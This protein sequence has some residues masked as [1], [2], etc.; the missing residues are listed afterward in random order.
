MSSVQRMARLMAAWSVVAL[1]ACG[2]GGGDPAPNDD[3]TPSSAQATS[4]TI[5]IESGSSST[6][7][8]TFTLDG[9]SKASYALGTIKVTEVEY[10]SDVFDV[11]KVTAS[12]DATKYILL[13]GDNHTNDVFGCASAGW[14]D[15]ELVQI[16]ALTPFNIGRCPS[17]FNIDANT[18]RLTASHVSLTGAFDASKRLKISVDIALTSAYSAE[19]VVESGSAPTKP[20]T[21]ILTGSG[22]ASLSAE[23]I[24]L[25]LTYR[26]S[27]GVTVLL[28]YPTG[29]PEKFILE[30]TPGEASKLSPAATFTNLKEFAYRCISSAWGVDELASL[31]KALDVLPPF[32]PST[33]TYSESEPALRFTKLELHAADDTLVISANAKWHL[34]MFP[35]A[36]VATSPATSTSGSGSFALTA[37]NGQNTVAI[38]LGTVQPVVTV[39]TTSA[40]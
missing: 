17:G 23:G 29:H 11:M 31:K 13:F 36:P 39:V 3:I 18:N 34:P 37:D 30:A 33:V 10:A 25:G 15:A 12:T 4:N 35:S 16:K 38:P 6:S 40:P 2:G 8:G 19:F 28:A 9:G 27:G 22:G 32:C 7:S 5:T 26:E 21:Y 1:S 14:T 20:G 24:P